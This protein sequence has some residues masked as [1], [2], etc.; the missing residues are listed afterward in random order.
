MPENRRWDAKKGSYYCEVIEA[1]HD[2]D[3]REDM[4]RIA[5]AGSAPYAVPEVGQLLSIAWTRLDVAGGPPF[6]HGSPVPR[7]PQVCGA[8][9]W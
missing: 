2:Q 7:Q 9:G 1:E 6:D 5:M 8:R 4:S 3:R